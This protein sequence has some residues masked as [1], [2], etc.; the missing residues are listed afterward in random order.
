MWIIIKLYDAP[1]RYRLFNRISGKLICQI[2]QYDFYDN[3][4]NDVIRLSTQ[5]KRKKINCIIINEIIVE[6]SQ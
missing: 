5:G 4:Y 3:W 1:I 2:T 6:S